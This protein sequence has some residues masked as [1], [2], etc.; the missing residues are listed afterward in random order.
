MLETQ[1]TSKDTELKEQAILHERELSEL[2][3]Q[4]DVSI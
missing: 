1:L 4:H 2:K 3:R